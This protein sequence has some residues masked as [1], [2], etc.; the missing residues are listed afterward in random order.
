L[1]S[2]ASRALEHRQLTLSAKRLA[3]ENERYRQHLERL[4]KERT[5]ALDQT[6]RRLMREI[7]ERVAAETFLKRQ[8]DLTLALSRA[9]TQEEMLDAILDAIHSL[10]GIDSSGIHILQDTYAGAPF[11]LLVTRG[12][13][14]NFPDYFHSI[15]PSTPMYEILL[16]GTPFY[17]DKVSKELDTILRSPNPE[18]LQDFSVISM[19][20]VRYG[21]RTVATLNTCT[22][23]SISPLS[24][25]FLEAIAE[26]LGGVIAR[27]SLKSALDEHTDREDAPNHFLAPPFRSWCAWEWDPASDTLFWSYSLCRVLELTNRAK[28]TPL[29]EFRTHL[30]PE[31]AE[32]VLA[33]VRDMAEDG[34]HPLA[35]RATTLVDKSGRAHP[36]LL[37]CRGPLPERPRCMGV[38]ISMDTAD[39]DAVAAARNLN[40]DDDS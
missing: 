18:M 3:E 24:R 34:S 7:E 38:F 2:T 6:N 19:I 15:S 40:A 4:V 37:V 17:T 1:L 10:D 11:E 25:R 28:A 30:Q 5:H 12:L 8:R 9:A 32:A 14:D 27:L 23:D 35:D 31:D 22:Q 16:K 21:G 29:D 26:C 20:P 13:P 39:I 33:M 36:M